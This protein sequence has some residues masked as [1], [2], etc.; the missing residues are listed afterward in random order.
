MHLLRNYSTD[1]AES[2]H[3]QGRGSAPDTAASRTVVAIAPWVPTRQPIMCCGEILYQY[4]LTDQLVCLY[5]GKYKNLAI[6][7]RSRVSCAHNTLRAS[8][9][10]LCPITKM[11]SRHYMSS[12]GCRCGLATNVIWKAVPGSRSCIREGPL[13]EHSPFQHFN[14]PLRHIPPDVSAPGQFPLPFHM[15]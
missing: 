14:I 5:H 1:L 10:V 7:N 12:E 3:A 8:S 2:V 6:A 13:T 4:A 15:V 9:S 11:I